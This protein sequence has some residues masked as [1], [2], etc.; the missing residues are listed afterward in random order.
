MRL[1]FMMHAAQAAVFWGDNIHRD[2]K[3]VDYSEPTL[4]GQSEIRFQMGDIDFRAEPD[5][6][7]QIVER[8]GTIKKGLALYRTTN[9][10]STSFTSNLLLTSVIGHAGTQY[11][12]RALGDAKHEVRVSIAGVDGLTRLLIHNH[13]GWRESLVAFGQLLPYWQAIESGLVAQCFNTPKEQVASNTTDEQV[14]SDT[15]EDEVHE[16]TTFQL[17][18]DLKDRVSTLV[19]HVTAILDDKLRHV[20]ETS[21]IKLERDI[22]KMLRALRKPAEHVAATLNL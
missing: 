17:D 11:L 21:S 16:E 5:A 22:A 4:V 7:L 8:I 13:E 15:T 6:L 14:A 10:L 19:Q 2:E 1:L 12:V 9:E 3:P 20:N 18:Q